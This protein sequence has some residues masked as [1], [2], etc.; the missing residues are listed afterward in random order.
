M[1]LTRV[2]YWV[3][4]GDKIGEEITHYFQ[5]RSGRRLA[6]ETV[7]RL[8]AINLTC[9]IAIERVVFSVIIDAGEKQDDG[10]EE[11]EITWFNKLHFKKDEITNEDYY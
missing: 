2:E 8:N 1:S 4:Q 7:E 6:R 5:G 9:C 11:S 3:H 10:I